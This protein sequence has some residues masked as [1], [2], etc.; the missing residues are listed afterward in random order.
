MVSSG[1]CEG[2]EAKG[3]GLLR[4]MGLRS[5]I[6]RFRVKGFGC[7]GLGFGRYGGWGYRDLGLGLMYGRGVGGS[8]VFGSFHPAP[9]PQTRRAGAPTL[10]PP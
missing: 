6:F 8:G 3:A 4:D 9:K 10:C 7:A 5:R 1:C 2:L